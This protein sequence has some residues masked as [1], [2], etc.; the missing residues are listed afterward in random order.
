MIMRTNPAYLELA[1]RKAITAELLDVLRSKY[2]P[3]Y[4]DDPEK[5]V[6][7]EDVFRDDSEVPQSAIEDFIGELEEREARLD[8]ELNRFE[9][10]KREGGDDSVTSK[11]AKASSVSRSPARKKAKAKRRPSNKA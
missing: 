3:A 10:V 11:K 7:C 6:V 2:T 5:K 1:Y 9:F 8:L 4:G